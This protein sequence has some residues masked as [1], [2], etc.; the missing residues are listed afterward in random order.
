[1]GSFTIENAGGQGSIL[2]WQIHSYPNW[3]NWIITPESGT[4]LESGETAT[5]DVDVVAP[6][7]PES[8]FSGSIK[9]VDIEN[10]EN[11]DTV[12]VTLSTPKNKALHT[13]PIFYQFIQRILE[14]FPI[15]NEILN[16]ILFV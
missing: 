12:S 15:L 6:N 5:V 1:M 4:N 3:G 8:D 9:V 16:K 13:L 10:S 2:N 7:E 14:K 11:Y